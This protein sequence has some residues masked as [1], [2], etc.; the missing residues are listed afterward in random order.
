LLG[1]TELDDFAVSSMCG[2]ICDL[3]LG[4]AV[5]ESFAGHREFR[6]PAGTFS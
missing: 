2:G 4:G 1:S 6:D 5:F 3:L